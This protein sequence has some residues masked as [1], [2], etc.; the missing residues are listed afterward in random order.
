MTD[1]NSTVVVKDGGTNSGL[2]LGIVAI[3][4]VVAAVWFFAIG[5]GAGT[6]TPGDVDINVN[7]PSIEVPAAS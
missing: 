7:L 4:I 1:R 5:P 3:L 6:T 2:I